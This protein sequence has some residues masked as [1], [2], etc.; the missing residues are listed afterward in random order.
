[1]YTTCRNKQRISCGFLDHFTVRWMLHLSFISNLPKD[2][3]YLELFIIQCTCVCFSNEI[4]WKG[5]YRWTIWFVYYRY[6]S[7]FF[8]KV[9]YNVIDCRW[10]RSIFSPESSVTIFS[11]KTFRRVHGPH[12]GVVVVVSYYYIKGDRIRYHSI[13]F[14]III[15][16][17]YITF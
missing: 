5:W 4:P 3:P 15:L 6:F 9:L 7:Y 14:Y 17:V 11:L 1:M 13:L 2:N 16:F 12:L 8:I 10:W